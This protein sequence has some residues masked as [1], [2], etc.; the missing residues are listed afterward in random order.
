MTTA[1]TPTVTRVPYTRFQ[2]IAGNLSGAVSESFNM[3]AGIWDIVQI[4]CAWDAPAGEHSE[5]IQNLPGEVTV[6]AGGTVSY[7]QFEWVYGAQIAANSWIHVFKPPAFGAVV[8]TADELRVR[9]EDL[10]TGGSSIDLFFRVT[11]RRLR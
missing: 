9:N 5:L 1:L 6:R 10:D 4:E 2:G 7:I 3:P 11:G 8:Y